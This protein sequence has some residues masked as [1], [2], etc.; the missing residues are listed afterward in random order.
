MIPTSDTRL[1]AE[2]ELHAAVAVKAIPKLDKLLA[3]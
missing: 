3:H 2:D 1:E